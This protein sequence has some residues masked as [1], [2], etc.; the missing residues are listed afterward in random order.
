M[1]Q[2]RYLDHPNKDYFEDFR[3]LRNSDYWPCLPPKTQEGILNLLDEHRY[4]NRHDSYHN[5]AP[6]SPRD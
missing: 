5:Q 2:K 4:E 1:D 3:I 6:P